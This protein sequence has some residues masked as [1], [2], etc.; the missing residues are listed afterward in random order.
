M[1]L[2]SSESESHYKKSPF[3]PDVIRRFPNP[4]AWE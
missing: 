2:V 1:V 4:W 3:T